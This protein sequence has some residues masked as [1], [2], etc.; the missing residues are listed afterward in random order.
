MDASVQGV[1]SVGV[2]DSKGVEIGVKKPL[3]R[4]NVRGDAVVFPFEHG[5]H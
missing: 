2:D 5:E 1:G 4:G 3:V